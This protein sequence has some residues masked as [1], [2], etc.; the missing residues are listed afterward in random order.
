MARV[1]VLPLAV[2]HHEV[3]LIRTI[4]INACAGLPLPAPGRADLICRCGAFSFYAKRTCR[5]F[6]SLSPHTGP[7]VS[8]VVY[9]D[10]L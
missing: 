1:N 9:A 10:V 2:G 3:L 6:D 5:R 4:V 8:V 7:S